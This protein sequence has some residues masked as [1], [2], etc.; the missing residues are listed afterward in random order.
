M[1]KCRVFVERVDG[2][3]GCEVGS[4]DINMRVILVELEDVEG[5]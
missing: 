3:V 4:S 1:D 5:G 2:G